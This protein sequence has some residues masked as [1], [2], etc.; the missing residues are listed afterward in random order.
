MSLFDQ[1]LFFFSALG[2]FNGFLLSV[3]F[4]FFIKKKNRATYFLSTLIFVI[5]IRVLKSVF[6]TYYPETSNTFIQIGLTACF[7]IG[8][9]LY[10]YVEEFTKTI[11]TKKSKRWLLHVIPVLIAMVF[12]GYFLPFRENYRLWNRIPFG[13]LGWLLLVQWLVYVLYSLYLV[14]NSLHNVFSKKSKATSQDFWIS[15]IVIGVAFIWIAYN[16]TMYTSYIVGALSFSF[17][18]YITLLIW[19]LKQRK[20]VLF[21]E[22]PSKYANKKINEIESNHIENKLQALFKETKI[23]KEPRLKL[24][25]LAFAIDETPHNLSKFLNDNLGKSFANYINEFRVLEATKMMKSKHE[26]TLEAIGLEC[27]FK[28]NSSFYTAFKKFTNLTPAQYKKTMV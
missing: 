1:I 22:M 5:S 17:T 26:F 7:L 8:P 9:F 14:K 25:D 2:A 15:N 4:A 28:S 12:I 3:Y 19:I 11:E 24:N 21:F 18:F 13:I 10:I 20:V 27:G 23:Y 16:T 6:L